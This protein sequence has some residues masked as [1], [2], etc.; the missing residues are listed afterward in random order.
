[1]SA[2]T[3]QVLEM[4][5]D[6]KIT[7]EDAE[8]LLEKLSGPSATPPGAPPAGAGAGA[9]PGA[10][11]GGGAARPRFLRIRVERPGRENVNMRVPLSLARAG[12]GW[13]TLIPPRVNERLAE[14]GIDLSALGDLKGEDIREA[15]ENLNVDIDKGDGKKVRVYCE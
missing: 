2:E 13:M 6:G 14:Q 10:N 7:P 1:M 11:P 9:Q 12:I 5:K 15:L 3:R 8:K 4:L